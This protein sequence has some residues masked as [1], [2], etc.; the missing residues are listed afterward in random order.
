[1][2]WYYHGESP[3]QKGVHTFIKAHN[4]DENI[5]YTSS[6][7]ENVARWILQYGAYT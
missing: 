1:M 3:L 2:Y 4:I 5:V 7:G 6:D